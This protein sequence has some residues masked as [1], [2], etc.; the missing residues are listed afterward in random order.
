MSRATRFLLLLPALLAG[1]CG[2][3]EYENKMLESQRRLERWENESRYLDSPL[4][5]VNRTDAD[6]KILPGPIVHLRPPRG[7][8]ASPDNGQKP[9]ADLL[10]SYKPRGGASTP[11]TMVEV[12]TAEQ[13]KEFPDDVLR[14]FGPSGE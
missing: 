2:V 14:S 11:F 6:G 7:I 8:N 9:R 4:T 1:A 5:I 3:N 12:A 10:F 13:A